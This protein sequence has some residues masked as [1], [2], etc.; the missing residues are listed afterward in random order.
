MLANGCTKSILTL[1]RQHFIKI[2]K[3]ICMDIKKISIP[4]VSIIDFRKTILDYLVHNKQNWE[5]SELIDSLMLDGFPKFDQNNI[6][7]FLEQMKG[8][9]FL[10]A[11]CV[12]FGDTEFYWLVSGTEAILVSRRNLTLG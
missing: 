10:E 5:L 7:S 2:W 4:I 6:K 8:E 11:V 12:D 3:V 9:F 1:A